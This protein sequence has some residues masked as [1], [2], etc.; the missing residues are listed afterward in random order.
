MPLNTVKCDGELSFANLTRLRIALQTHLCMYERVFHKSLTE[1]DRPISI[2]G[3]TNP[4]TAVPDQFR[5][6]KMSWAQAL[7]HLL[8]L[9]DSRY[10]VIRCLST[11]CCHATTRELKAIATLFPQFH[12]RFGSKERMVADGETKRMCHQHRIAIMDRRKQPKE[13]E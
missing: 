3:S 5:R 7:I 11:P 2:M 6:N 4:Q 12:Q 8:K 10:N 1:Q 9:P 13:W